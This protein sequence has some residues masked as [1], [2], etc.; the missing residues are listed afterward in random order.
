MASNRR[1]V[2]L[3]RASDAADAVRWLNDG[4]PP[5]AVPSRWVIWPAILAFLL[6]VALTVAVLRGMT[7]AADVQLELGLHTVASLPLTGLMYL[8]TAFGYIPVIGAITAFLCYRLLQE[9]RRW[10]AVAVATVMLG[11]G[12]LNNIL[13]LAVHRTRPTLFAHTTTIGLSFPSGHAMATFCLV[14]VILWFTWRYLRPLVRCLAI[15]A[16][17]SF[18]VLVGVS[19]VYLGVHYPTDVVGG[20]LASAAWLGTVP[21]LLRGLRSVLLARVDETI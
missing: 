15:V 3:P 17:V 21:I 10:E 7:M 4:R 5:I 18:V 14:G 9:Q 2:R 19:R 13:K 8:L 6:F 11:E 12:A 1:L 16:G 20:W